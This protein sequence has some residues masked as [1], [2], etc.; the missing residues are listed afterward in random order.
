GSVIAMT[1]NNAGQVLS[2]SRMLFALA[3]HGHLPAFFGYVHPR[4]R[5]PSNAVLFTSVIA[6]VLALTGSFATIAV[7]SAVARLVTYSGVSAATLRL[8]SPRFADVVP[9]ARFT[10]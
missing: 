3:E 6:L 5:T 7:V 2:G 9:P 8:R 1:G 10:I 4:F